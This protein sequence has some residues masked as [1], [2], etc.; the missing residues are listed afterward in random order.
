MST[1]PEGKSCGHVL[2]LLALVFDD[3]RD[4]SDPAFA[5]VSEV[6]NSAPPQFDKLLPAM[7]TAVIMIAVF[8]AGAVDLFTAALIASGVMLMSGCLTQNAA[9][10]AVKWVGPGILPVLAMC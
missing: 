9:R 5:L 10:A 6:E 8:V 4:R 2:S 3:P 1:H 7:S